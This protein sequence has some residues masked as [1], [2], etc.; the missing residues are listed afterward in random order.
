MAPD[1]IELTFKQNRKEYFFNPKEIELRP[2]D[3]AIIEVEKGVDLGQV[4]Q[5][6]RLVMLKDIKHEPRNI[7]RKATEADLDHLNEN[8]RK[9]ALAFVVGKEY[10]LRHG[11]NMKLVD[12]EYQLDEN[13]LTFYFTSD[14]RVD[15]RELVKSL[16]NKYRTRIELR[17]IGVR[18]EARRLGGC[19]ICGE[20]LCCSTFMHSFSPITTQDA[21]DQNLPMNPSKLSGICGRLK[22]CLLFEK[23]F[24][25]SSLKKFPALDSVVKT[26]RGVGYVDKIDIFNDDVLLRFD[27]DEYE[28]YPL[29]QV[30]RWLNNGN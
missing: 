9:E 18:E 17:Q 7:V 29:E 21:K 2:G 24:Y 23:G 15:F 28:K 25:S 27:G 12:V 1:I 13:K 19:G 10:I 16:A 3:Y 11:L 22:C 6:G 26:A 14:Q 20:S 4:T 30:N 5:V 8:R